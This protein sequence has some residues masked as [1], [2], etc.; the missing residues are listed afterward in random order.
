MDRNFVKNQLK[1]H[2]DMLIFWTNSI[3]FWKKYP[4]HNRIEEIKDII[5]RTNI[6]I[7]SLREWLKLKRQREL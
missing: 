2:E 7:I 1:N 6:I 4:E 3:E 5:H